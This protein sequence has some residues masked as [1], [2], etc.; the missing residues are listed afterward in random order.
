M[1]D[2][3]VA[4]SERVVATAASAE[5]ARPKTASAETFER[6]TATRADPFRVELMM[7]LDLFVR[8]ERV[9][10]SESSTYTRALGRVPDV[11]GSLTHYYKID[12]ARATRN[13]LLV[14]ATGE[15]RRGIASDAA[16]VG[17]RIAIDESFRVK[18]NFPLPLPPRDYLHTLA[19]NVMNRIYANQYRLPE[20]QELDHWEGVFRGFFRYEVRPVSAGGRAIVAVGVRAPVKGDIVETPGS[21]DLF[22]WVYHHRNTAWA[23]R[24][25]QGHLESIFL[26]ERIQQEHTGAFSRA[27]GELLTK[28]IGLTALSSEQSPVEVQDVQLDP[29]FGFHAEIGSRS[30]AANAEAVARSGPV[31]AWSINGYGQ[32]SE[33]ATIERIMSEFDTTRKKVEGHGGGELPGNA[34]TATIDLDNPLK[35]M[36]MSQ[37]GALVPGGEAEKGR[38]PLLIDAVDG[39]K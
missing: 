39:D 18:T 29:T 11:L 25:M 22:E 4:S 36:P 38:K 35:L 28:W 15:A 23:G 12:I 20:T 13:Q 21:S 19:R 17:D 14:V 7:A 24:E 32:V 10:R 3:S 5:L 2:A 26:A 30:P 1:A 9:L 8:A 33:V 37:A 6:G 34:P 16:T 27:Y 31:Q